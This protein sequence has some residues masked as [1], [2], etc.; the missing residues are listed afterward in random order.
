MCKKC[1]VNFVLLI[2]GLLGFCI[3]IRA[4][5]I[6]TVST[7][8]EFNNVFNRLKY[9]IG[10]SE[11]ATET[12]TV[13]FSE[14]V[15][16]YNETFTF[17]S[18]DYPNVRVH[19][20]AKSG[21]TVNLIADGNEYTS[22]EATK[23]T[24]T[25]YFVPLK[26]DYT[27]G[28]V[29]VDQ[30]FNLVPISDSGNLSEKKIHRATSA[31]ETLSTDHDNRYSID[32]ARFKFPEELS[33]LKNKETSFFKDKL[34]CFK[35]WFG[36]AYGSIAKTDDEY[37]YFY[38]PVSGMF[39]AIEAAPQWDSWK[40][41]PLFYIANVTN[42]VN[43]PESGKILVA[44]GGIYIPK[45]VTKLYECKKQLLGWFSD[46]NL[47]E[48]K[49]SNL[50]FSG[51]AYY[52][53]ERYY[54]EEVR[55]GSRLTYDGV[56]YYRAS[57]I[58]FANTE[59]VVFDNCVFRNI[60]SATCVSNSVSQN[61]D[62]GRSFVFRNNE[63][64]DIGGKVVQSYMPNTVIENNTVHNT[65]FFSFD[66]PDV[67]TMTCKNYQVKNNRISDFKGNGLTLGYNMC[68]LMPDHPVSGVTEGNEL[69]FTSEF[70]NHLERYTLEDVHAIYYLNHHD[71]SLASGNVVH[72]FEGYK[73]VN[74]T[75]RCNNKA[76]TID[77]EGYNVHIAGNLVFNVADVAFYAGHASTSMKSVSITNN[78]FFAPYQIT[79]NALE[80]TSCITN[81]NYI[82]TNIKDKHKDVLT[83]LNTVKNNV[84]GGADIMDEEALV[85]DGKCF[86]TKDY[87]SLD[88]STFVKQWLAPFSV[89]NDNV[90]SDKN[91]VW[92]SGKSL[93]IRSVVKQDASIYSADG[94]LV[95]A[96]NLN[97]GENVCSLTPGFYVVK[98]GD[99]TSQKIYIE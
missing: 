44:E 37:I 39:R 43:Q 92:A 54:G 69:F 51:A 26:N 87:S 10:Q 91:Q 18:I 85:E 20:T 19:L 23:E 24:D 21:E 4:E 17:Y 93:H 82:A 90:A 22:S 67:F 63:V 49:F 41:Y 38:H 83:G 78:V 97:D 61:N 2:A 50:N 70:L 35:L 6:L 3:P 36:M 56:V 81:N 60:G 68:S 74:G 59:H 66:R 45:G 5:K 64:Y 13:Y 34:I 65:G 15:Y 46:V 86:L 12:F 40:G 96:L 42:A 73:F 16:K 7:Q 55:T 94:R 32:Y 98:L 79:G 29:Y 47:K 31:R 53:Y 72:D 27:R 25:H 8:A 28:E 99:G 80:P 48:L 52:D 89:S 57:F 88:L 30:N 62:A 58:A 76:F 1:C 33:F 14:G 77:C 75:G 95:K 11:N 9:E 84:Q 71:Y